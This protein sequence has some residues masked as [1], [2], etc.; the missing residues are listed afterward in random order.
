MTQP[1]ISVVI[2]SYNQA[3]FIGRTLQSV[4]TQ[5]YPDLEVIV[6]DGGSS[7]G[8][9]EIIRSVAEHTAYAVS[10][11]DR[12]QSHAINKGFSR[13]TGTIVTWLN[14][15]DVLLPGALHAPLGVSGAPSRS[16]PGG[17]A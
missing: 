9:W 16:G 6:I 5:G 11:K 7:D 17:G 1:R 2:P 14:S 4:V 15:D 3:Q 8:S 10:E 13:A 12:G